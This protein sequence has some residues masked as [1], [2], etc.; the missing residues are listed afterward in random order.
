LVADPAACLDIVNGKRR[1]RVS[2]STGMIPCR[3]ATTILVPLSV[4]LFFD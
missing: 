1:I 3:R 4:E 2:R